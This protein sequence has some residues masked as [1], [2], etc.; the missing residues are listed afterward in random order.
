MELL[1]NIRYINK[2][3]TALLATLFIFTLVSSIYLF[4]TLLDSRS[5]ISSGTTTVSG[6]L[7]IQDMNINLKT[8]ESSLRGYVITNNN[9]YLTSYNAAIKVIP[10]E[11]K[12]LKNN[13]YNINP[14]ELSSLNILVTKRVDMLKHGIDVSDRQGSSAVIASISANNGLEISTQIDKLMKSITR[15]KFQPYTVAYQNMLNNLQSALFVAGTLIGFMFIISLLLASYFQRAIGR[16]RAT[17]GAKNEFLSLASH[18]LR[19]PASNVKQYLGLLLEGYL[20][21][22]KPEQTEAIQVANRNNDMG[23]KIIND[24]LGVAKLDLDK[25]RLKKKETNVYSLI[26]ETVDDYRP[27]LRERRQTVKFERAVKK[28]EANIDVQYIKSVFENLIDNASKYSPKKSRIHIRVEQDAKKV[29]VSIKDEGAGISKKERAKL[30]KKFSRLPSE[31]TLNVEGS[32]LG[33]YWVKQIVELHGGRINVRS[34]KG[35]GATFIVELPK[36]EA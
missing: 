13:K 14:D 6:V 36:A 33:L 34:R 5:L 4:E 9:K 11:Q 35:K 27:Q 8:A 19:T 22:L 1:K 32:G 18:Q 12:A 25:I 24:L 2:G 16:E 10:E 29:I 31:A 23:I 20:G 17:E 30:F 26:K 3:L 21:K 7:L 15:E 28:A